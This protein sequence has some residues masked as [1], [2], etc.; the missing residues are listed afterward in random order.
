[1]G[2]WGSIG[3]IF[4]SPFSGIGGYLDAR[5]EEKNFKH[6]DP[7]MGLNP[8]AL[9]ITHQADA[10]PGINEMALG[11]YAMKRGLANAKYGDQGLGGMFGGGASG[12]ASP[13]ATGMPF[14]SQGGPGGMAPGN[15][16]LDP[17][18]QQLQNALSMFGFGG[19]L[20]TGV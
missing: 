15:T 8:A 14:V 20:P 19:I 5:K 1:M 16:T 18:L 7:F 3:S 13:Q 17:R 4:G 10:L 2:L 12:G 6:M 11:N 9:A